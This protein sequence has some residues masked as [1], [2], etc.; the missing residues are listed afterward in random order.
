MEQPNQYNTPV[1]VE[2]L[3]YVY[4]NITGLSDLIN[5][6]Y[7]NFG[8]FQEAYLWIEDIVKEDRTFTIKSFYDAIDGLNYNVNTIGSRKGCVTVA[9]NQDVDYNIYY[10][11]LNL[12]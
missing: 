3:I 9:N 10:G 1:T 4:N 2:T 7:K 5:I 12:S 11:H 6:E 8:D